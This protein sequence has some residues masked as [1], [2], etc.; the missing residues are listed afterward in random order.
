LGSNNKIGVK[1]KAREGV[2][3]I[4]L[5]QEPVAGSCVYGNEP[6]GSIKGVEFFDMLNDYQ[7]FKKDSG[8][9]SQM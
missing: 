8:P 2:D 6:S 7:L 4:H 9:W 3:W 5:A 1:E